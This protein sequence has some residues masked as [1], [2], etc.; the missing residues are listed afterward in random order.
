[1]VGERV[2]IGLGSN[3]GDGPAIVSAAWRTIGE[4]AR[5][6]TVAISH[7][8][9]SSPVGMDSRHW[10]TNCVGEL[11]TDLT[12]Q[13]LLRTLLGIEAAFGRTR[14]GKVTGYQD[15]VLDLDILY[16]GDL[17]LNEPGLI[18]PHPRIAERLFVLSPLAEIA[19]EWRGGGEVSVRQMEQ[20][21]LDRMQRSQIPMQEIVC[22]EW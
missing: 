12:A 7:P 11:K 2:F 10:F 17:S 16:F 3:L 8:Y 6:T 15:R 4:E 5:I 20:S 19:P 1:M 13:E 9:V 18:L 21:L 22:R 14:D